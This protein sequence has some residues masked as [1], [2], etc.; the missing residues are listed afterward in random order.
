MPA[1]SETIGK[2]ADALAKFQGAMKPIERDREVEV[3]KDG[4]RLYAFRYSTMERIVEDTRALLSA[5]SLA[6]A[7]GLDGSANGTVVTTLLMHSSGEWIM[8]TLPTIIKGS[9]SQ[10][11]GSA[12]SYSK[13]Y[14]LTAI[15]GIVTEDDDDGNGAD[16]QEVKDLSR[17]KSYRSANDPK[18]TGPLP[19]SALKEQLRTLHSEIDGCQ[20][21]DQL[22]STLA[23]NAEKVNQC[24]RDMPTWWMHKNGGEVGGLKHAI[25]I[26]GQQLNTPEVK[27]FIEAAEKSEAP[28][29][30]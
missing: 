24:A 26:A 27:R 15:L 14:A 2:L 12:I 3:K 7:Q 25:H 11:M 8:T 18:W 22:I 23:A 5:N 6:W 9:G 19:M 16:G 17:P 1:K 21:P 28:A 29:K 4:K 30:K 20:D 10:D 13:R